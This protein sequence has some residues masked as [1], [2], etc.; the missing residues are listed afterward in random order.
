M[1]RSSN[2]K[3]TRIFT[4]II[5]L[6]LLVSQ[7]GC[8][9]TGANSQAFSGLNP[10]QPKQLSHQSSQQQYQANYAQYPQTF[11]QQQQPFQQ[12]QAYQSQGYQPQQ[13][14][15]NQMQNGFDPYARRGATSPIGFQGGINPFGMGRC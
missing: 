5:G 6:I 11:G 2:L 4:A 3:T 7:S 1:K 14:Y 13:P 15:A 8:Y 10:F 9:S 12:A